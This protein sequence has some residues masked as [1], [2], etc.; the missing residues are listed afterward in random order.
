MTPIRLTNMIILLA[1]LATWRLTYL[2]V[3][4]DG[5][6]N[7]FSAFRDK[8]GVEY[9]N[10]GNVSGKNMI[11]KLFACFWCASIWVAALIS[12]LVLL[13]EHSGNYVEL[14]FIYFLSFSAGAIILKEK[15]L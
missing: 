6:F 1:I 4:E 12:V 8:I 3:L 10:F 5:P 15:I 2:F 7:I 11:A 13:I 9:D 14:F